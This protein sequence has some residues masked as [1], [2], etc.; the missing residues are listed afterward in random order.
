M[1]PVEASEALHHADA[2]SAAG[3]ASSRW[4][5]RW[6]AIFAVMSFGL[7]LGVGLTGGPRAIVVVMVVWGAF[8]VA[9]TAWS[10]RQQT[11]G[12]GMTRTHMAVMICWAVIWGLVVV[13]GSTRFVGEPGW[14]VPGGLAL[15][16]PPLV[17]AVR[18][19]RRLRS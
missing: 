15:A 11:W 19:A 17:G 2:L 7:S 4:Y 9:L 16:A 6:L 18:V 14:W 1:N 5:I 3:R 8:I 13:L 12:P 10:A